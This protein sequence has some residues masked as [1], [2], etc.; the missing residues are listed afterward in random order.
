[1]GKIKV[2]AENAERYD[3]WFE[4]HYN[5][6]IAELAAIQK[7]MPNHERGIEIGVGS[8]RFAAPL[9]IKFGIDPVPEMLQKAA[10]RGIEVQQGFAE[11]LLYPSNSFD[12]ALMTCT[13]CF[14]DNIDQAFAEV[15]RVLEIDRMFTVAFIDKN[16]QLGQKY[17]NQKNNLFY[18]SATFYSPDG[19]YTKL[20][21]AGFEVMET[22]QTLLPGS[23]DSFENCS[24]YGKGAFVVINSKKIKC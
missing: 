9:G 10:A 11:N 13:I 2:F 22:Y 7:A 15:A 23:N 5:I 16:S 12:Y 17:Q 4:Q 19:I 6:F 1:M 8:G 24:G 3:Q 20:E 14:L 18:A 21:N